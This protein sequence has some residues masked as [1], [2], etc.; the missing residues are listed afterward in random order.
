[1]IALLGAALAAPPTTTLDAEVAVG[2]RLGGAVSV[3]LQVWRGLILGARGWVVT[4][5][6]FAVPYLGSFDVAYNLHMAALP[7]VGWRLSPGP[8]D[9]FDLDLTFAFGPELLLVDETASFPERGVSA[10]YQAI[11]GSAPAMFRL[12]LRGWV[13][14]R[15][16]IEGSL[17]LP[18]PLRPERA[19]FGLGLARRW[20][21]AR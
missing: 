12:A 18:A 14:P 3:D 21:G 1:M 8:R 6:Y 10:R 9:R 11:D 19:H 16:A 17:S 13:A 7:S 5:A 4:D 15:W 20:G 2:L